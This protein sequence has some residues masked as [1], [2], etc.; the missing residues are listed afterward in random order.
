MGTSTVAPAGTAPVERYEV[1]AETAAYE[2]GRR[3]GYLIAACVCG[4]GEHVRDK[5]LGRAVVAAWRTRHERC[6]APADG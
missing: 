2:V 6:T 4:S 5:G 1:I 3:D